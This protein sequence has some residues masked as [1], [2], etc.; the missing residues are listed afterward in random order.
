MDVVDH[1]FVDS[2]SAKRAG[3]TL[4]VLQALFNYHHR[5]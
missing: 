2:F 3:K 1:K 4:F 5:W